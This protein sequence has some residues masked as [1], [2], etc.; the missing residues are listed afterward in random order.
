MTSQTRRMDLMPPLSQDVQQLLQD[1]IADGLVTPALEL[2]GLQDTPT[3]ANGPTASGC[4]WDCS[5]STEWSPG[6]WWLLNWWTA[7]YPADPSGSSAAGCGEPNGPD[8]VAPVDHE[9][10]DRSLAPALADLRERHE[11]MVP[12]P[13]P[14]VREVVEQLVSRG[15]GIVDLLA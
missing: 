8:P 1:A 13:P 15:A 12:P 6:L 2:D 9:V 5:D 11:D 3:E 14:V 4:T 7:L 10:D